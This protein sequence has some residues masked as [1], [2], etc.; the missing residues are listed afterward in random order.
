MAINE[1][2]LLEQLLLVFIE[3]GYASTS[4]RELAGRCGISEMTLF[5]KYGSKQALFTATVLHYLDSH[6]YTEIGLY[7]TDTFEGTLIQLLLKRYEFVV[8]HHAVLSMLLGETLLHKWPQNFNV[9]QAMQESNI[10]LITRCA[11]HHQLVVDASHL[12]MMMLG[13]LMNELF[14][15]KQGQTDWTIAETRRSRVSSYIRYILSLEE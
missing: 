13:F 11:D 8:T 1:S 7:E 10:N 9:F 5:R 3:K 6:S 15:F 14:R 4:T 2:T 12:S